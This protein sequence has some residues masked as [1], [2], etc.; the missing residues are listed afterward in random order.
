MSLITL[1]LWVT[2]IVVFLGG[3]VAL[4]PPASSYP[5]PA[6]ITTAITTLYQ[7]LYSFNHILPVD[8]MI[9]ILKYSIVLAFLTR[10]LWPSLVWIFESLTGTG[11]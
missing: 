2:G 4:L 8:T 5:Y 11:R 9:T 10:L 3:M 6:D 1:S 7:W